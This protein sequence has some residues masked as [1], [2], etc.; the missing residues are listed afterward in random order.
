MI[1]TSHISFWCF[2]CENFQDPNIQQPPNIHHSIINQSHQDVHHIPRTGSLYPLVTLAS[3]V[4]GTQT[5]SLLRL[6][7]FLANKTR[8]LVRI[9]LKMYFN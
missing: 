7:L 5:A 6:L 8:T 1:N 4:E 2:S 9:L 3:Q